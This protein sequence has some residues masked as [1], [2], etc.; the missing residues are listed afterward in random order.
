MSLVANICI[1][2]L[3]IKIYFDVVSFALIIFAWL[4]S[5]DAF[6]DVKTLGKIIVLALFLFLSF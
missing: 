4:E 6:A 2:T 5:I 1:L 3:M